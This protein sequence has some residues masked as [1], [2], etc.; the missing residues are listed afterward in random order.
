MGGQQ[1]KQQAPP[2]PTTQEILID[3]KLAAK[4]FERD[5]KKAEKEKQQQYLKAQQAIKK[6][7]E[8]GA[9]LY[10]QNMMQKD[11]EMKNM[12]RMSQKMD[13][14]Q[15]QIKTNTS[16]TAMIE[17]ISRITP[18]LGQQA[19][20]MSPEAIYSNMDQYEKAMDDILVGGKIMDEVMN[21]NQDSDV[22]GNIAIDGMLNQLKLENMNEINNINDNNMVFN[23]LKNNELNNQQMNNKQIIDN[24]LKK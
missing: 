11:R 10:L 19:H 7:N 2:P 18:L 13:A 15:M 17:Q 4:S 9:K 24:N 5:A 22:N 1:D 3:M 21:K 23:E 6:N 12:Q 16:N 8:E 20:M 14:L